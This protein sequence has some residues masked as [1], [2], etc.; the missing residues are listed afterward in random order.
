ME[1]RIISQK[2]DLYQVE[3]EE[4]IYQCKARGKF[5]NEEISPVVG[6]KVEFQILDKEKKE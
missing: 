3:M 2:S 5:K 6:D 4:K 1:G